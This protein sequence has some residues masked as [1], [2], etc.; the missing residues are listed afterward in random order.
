[1]DVGFEVSCKLKHTVLTKVRTSCWIPLEG[2]L[3]MVMS[4]RVDIGN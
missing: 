1:M 2:Q 3:Q 4:C